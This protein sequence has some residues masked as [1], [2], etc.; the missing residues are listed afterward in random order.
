MAKKKAKSGVRYA[1]K[2]RLG[3]DGRLTR[4]HLLM[5]IWLRLSIVR[6]QTMQRSPKVVNVKEDNGSTKRM[7]Q[8]ELGKD[9]N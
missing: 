7:A 9:W 1:L 2:V 5:L 4:I 3:R 8:A 6:T